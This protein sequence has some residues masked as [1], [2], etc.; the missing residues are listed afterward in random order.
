MILRISA[1]VIGDLP[2]QFSTATNYESDI[3]YQLLRF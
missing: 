3:P 1:I 2:L